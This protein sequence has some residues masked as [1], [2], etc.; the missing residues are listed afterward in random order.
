MA[1]IADDSEGR[2]HQH[3]YQRLSQHLSQHSG[4]HPQPA[5]LKKT[6]DINPRVMT[7]I[8]VSVPS[9]RYLTIRLDN[10]EVHC[11]IEEKE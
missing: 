4:P 7:Y 9:G 11:D 8:R 5:N 2:R 10:S 6:C 3:W 1:S